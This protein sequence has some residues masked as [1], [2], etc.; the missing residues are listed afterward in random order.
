MP[1]SKNFKNLEAT[2]NVEPT[3]SIVKREETAVEVVSESKESR[4][5]SDVN[6]V[7]SV[8]NS[9]IEKSKEALDDALRLAQ[10]TDQARA[11]EVVGQLVKQTVESAEKIIDIHVKLKEMGSD[12]SSTT[13]V[14]QNNAI[15][16]GRTE[17]ALKLIR[18]AKLNENNNL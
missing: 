10:E 8:L 11:Y 14:T 17:D 1:S 3:P 2:F 15:F 12:K 5:D 9:T 4:I 16:V 6:Y 7:F 13:N 18:Q